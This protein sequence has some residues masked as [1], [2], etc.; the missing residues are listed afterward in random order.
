MSATGEERRHLVT[1]R[2]RL[3]L[4]PSKGDPQTQF[5]SRGTQIAVL[6]HELCHLRHMNHGKATRDKKGDSARLGWPL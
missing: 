4:H 3:R 6:L 2:L 1:I 5:V